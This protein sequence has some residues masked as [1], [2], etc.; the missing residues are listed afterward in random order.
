MANVPSNQLRDAY[1]SMEWGSERAMRCF[2]RAWMLIYE[3]LSLTGDWELK[4][5]GTTILKVQGGRP[6]YVSMQ[7]ASDR[8][9]INGLLRL[10]GIDGRFGARFVRGRALWWD[11][12]TDRT[13]DISLVPWRAMSCP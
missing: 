3:P 6:T 4:H 7:S 12:P 1:R 13:V 2:G 9:G 5:Y 8:D 11:G 10:M